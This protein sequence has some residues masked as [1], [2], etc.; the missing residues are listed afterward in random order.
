VKIKSLIAKLDIPRRRLLVSIRQIES[1]DHRDANIDTLAH[2]SSEEPR[3]KAHQYSTKNLH[4]G[5]YQVH[6]LEGYKAFI[7]F[8]QSV[9]YE[10]QQYFSIGRYNAFGRT[11][12]HR[13]VSNGFL[14]IPRLKGD[15]VEL[16][17]TLRQ[18]PLQRDQ[19]KILEKTKL[20]TF[21][22]G[23]VGQWIDLGTVNNRGIEGAERQLRSRTIHSAPEEPIIQVKV[24][25]KQ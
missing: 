8:E 2:P 21:I 5:I 25:L 9:P 13:T 6:A 7:S 1:T 15:L 19:D 3:L 20:K 4:R 18:Q 12:K 10:D 11:I 14:I 17:I 22:R 24:E 16:E 23:H